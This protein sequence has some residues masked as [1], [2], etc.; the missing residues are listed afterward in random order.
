MPLTWEAPDFGYYAFRN[1]WRGETDIILQLFGKAHMVGGW[2]GPNAGSFRLFGLGQSWNG[3][4]SGREMNVWQ[5]NRV[6]MP[7][8]DTFDGACARVLSVQTAAD[9]SGGVSLDMSDCYAG[10]AGGGYTMYGSLRNPSAFK[11][12][13]IRALR[14]IAVDYSGR[15]GAPGL[16]V[17]VDRLQ[18]GGRKVWTWNLGDAQELEKVT[19][20]GST[21]AIAK[22]DAVLHGTFV[23]PAGVA[24]E[25]KV[26]EIP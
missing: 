25:A 11:D 23:S 6:V 14:C 18:G 4:Y 7:D 16:F 22:G 5:E 1:G 13:G 10:R 9:G 24:I 2:N 8:D 20:T 12:L 17:L 26:N 19:I 21:F 3:D 15:C